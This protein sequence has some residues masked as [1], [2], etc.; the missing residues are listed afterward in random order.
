G[1]TGRRGECVV[2]EL[3]F[4]LGE[5]GGL[6]EPGHGFLERRSG[7]EHRR[8]CRHCEEILSEAVMDFARDACALLR[9]GTAELGELNCAPGADEHHGVR[10]HAEEV[11]L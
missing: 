1:G 10:E 11:A 8:M 2:C 3:G 6:L 4:L 7:F 9:D 5:N